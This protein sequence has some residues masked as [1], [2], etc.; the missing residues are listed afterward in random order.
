MRPSQLMHYFQTATQLVLV[1]ACLQL[2]CLCV[3]SAAS[4]AVVDVRVLDRS[5]APVRDVVVTMSS[6]DSDSRTG[7]MKAGSNASHAMVMDQLQMM[8]TPQVLLVPIGTPVS[9]P[10]SDSVSHQ[11][12]SFSRTKPFQLPLYKGKTYP[13]V[14]FDKPGLVVLGCNIHDAM[15][16]YIYVTDARWYGQTNSE[17]RL[18]L[19][20]V[21]AG[22]VNVTIWSPIIA[23]A[24]NNLS[25]SVEVVGDRQELVFKMIR[26]LRS[27]PEPK[28]RRADWDY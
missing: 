22:K 14:M 9:F 2:A 13:P 7:A 8:F 15:V 24:N 25:R 21:S 16:G 11:V 19:S 18:S 17:G 28:P 27:S 12:Y 10:N 6:T 1:N 23:D 26:P 5:G 3:A 20:D 4:A